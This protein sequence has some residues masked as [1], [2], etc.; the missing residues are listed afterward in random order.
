[1]NILILTGKFGMGHWVASQSLQQFLQHSF[2]DAVIKVEDFCAYAMPGASDVMYKFFHMLVTH[3]THLFNTY[4][5]LTALGHSDACPPFEGLFLDKLLE[6]LYRERPDAV[7]ATHPLCAQ[8]V[9]RLKEKA[10]LQE[11]YGLDLPLF[12]CVT[13]ISSHPEWINRNTDCYLVPSQEVRESLTGKGVDPAAVCVTGIP[14]REEFRD[15]NFCETRAC[16]RNDQKR[17][18]KMREL[19]IMGGGL[20]LLPAA[21]AFY[22]ALSEIP[23]THITVITGKNEKLFR[24]LYGRWENITV[25]GYADRVWDYMSRADMVVTKPGGITLFES[26]F[27]QVPIFSWPPVLCQE[28]NNARWLVGRGIGWVAQEENCAREISEILQDGRRL[29]LAKVCMGRLCK[30]LEPE[31]LN[32]MMEVIARTKEVA[33]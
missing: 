11:K 18:R 20:G 26:I 1:M 2:P 12:T 9:S 31:R 8:L 22:E 33:V 27:A 30:Q 15:L 21:T 10:G 32:R 19:L 17:E 14:V 16:R 5:K 25:V 28:R 3:G 7:I 6:L 13:D 24:R 23:D 29:E 4:Y